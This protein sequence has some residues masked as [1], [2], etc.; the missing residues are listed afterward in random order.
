[1]SEAHAFRGEVKSKE[2]LGIAQH[3]KSNRKEV[4][5]VE[6][7]PTGFNVELNEYTAAPMKNDDIHTF[8]RS[9]HLVGNNCGISRFFKQ[10]ICQKYL[11]FNA[12]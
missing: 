9:A 3:L 2:A 11:K 12:N 5:L 6:W 7:C 8:K 1:M 10:R 4:T